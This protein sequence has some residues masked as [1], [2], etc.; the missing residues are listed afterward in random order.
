MR[1]VIA[2]EV[3]E[4]DDVLAVERVPAPE[5]GPG[6]V[7]VRV[8]TA[9]VHA[10]DL[11]LMRGRYG[12]APSFP[13]VLGLEGVGMVAALGPGVGGGAQ[14]LRLGRRVATV[15]VT[16]TWQEFVVADASRVLPVP[17]SLSTST[18]AQMVIAPLT[19]WLLVTHLGLGRGDWL[20]QTAAGSTVGQLVIALSH[21]LGFHTLNVIR[22]RA[23][24]ELIHAR[25]GT[26]VIC[27]ED[28]D[29]PERLAH[30]TADRPITRAI[31]CVAGQVGAEVSRVLAP[32]GELVVYGALSTHRQTDPAML[33]IPVSA[34]SVVYGSKTVRGFF[35]PHW[36][37]TTSPD[38][39]RRALES[40]I[41]L[42]ETAVMV[43]PEGQPI[44]ADRA[45]HA[46]RLAETAGRGGRPLLVF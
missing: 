19:A 15:G 26:E 9:P 41:A 7:L 5:P 11:H 25:G 35:L 4:P 46:A 2:R 10:S 14:G 1:A 6:Q 38:D 40:V 30:H 13:A 36:F 21:H 16:G 28:E 37:A 39:V 42:V 8:D 12:F 3:G 45:A 44:P 24:A 22:R 31:D 27:T 17:E 29:L 33:T 20:L 43:I 34:P 23:A 18:A 32:G